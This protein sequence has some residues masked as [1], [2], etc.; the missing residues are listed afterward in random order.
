M[1][2][3]LADL[4]PGERSTIRDFTEDNEVVSRL[5]VMGLTEGEAV[6][7]VRLAPLGDPIEIRVRHYHLSLRRREAAAVLVD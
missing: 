6:E 2:R 4:Q 5:L 1:S 3:T 7:V